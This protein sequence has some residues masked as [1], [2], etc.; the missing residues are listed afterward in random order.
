[1]F[2][3]GKASGTRFAFHISDLAL[4]LTAYNYNTCVIIMRLLVHHG[5]YQ[6][7]VVPC[8]HYGMFKVF[9]QAFLSECQ[10][11]G[12]GGVLSIQS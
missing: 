8:H 11:R 4:C 5:E 3:N 2:Q 12:G 1:M 9:S 6:A 7:F 10:G